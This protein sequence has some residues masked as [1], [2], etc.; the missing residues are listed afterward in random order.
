MAEDKHYK[1][2]MEYLRQLHKEGATITNWLPN[3]EYYDNG[4]STG[5]IKITIDVQEKK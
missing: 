4:K 3:Y 1:T 5:K 2:L